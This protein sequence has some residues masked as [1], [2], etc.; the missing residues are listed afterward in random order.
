MSCIVV[1]GASG[2]LGQ[3]VCRRLM[4][5]GNSVLGLTHGER[6][7]PYV[8]TRPA[9]LTDEASVEAAYDAALRQFGEIVGSVHTAGGWEGG[10]VAETSLATFE[11][12][13]AQNLR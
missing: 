2:H 3:V 7:L 4:R 6:G 8:D 10:T 12:M 13:I 9:E 5:N 11:K 1:T